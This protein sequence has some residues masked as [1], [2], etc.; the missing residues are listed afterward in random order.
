MLRIFAS[1]WRLHPKATAREF[2]LRE[3]GYVTAGVRELRAAKVGDTLTHAGK[4][5]RAPL[6]ASRRSSPRVFAGLYPVE[7]SE[8]EH[9]AT[10]WRNCT[11]TTHR[12]HYEPE[13]SQA[14]G[15]GFRCGFLVC[16]TW[17]SCRNGSS[18]STA[19]I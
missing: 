4:P 11:S 6:P 1:R 9:C 12:F 16:C 7:A 14:L 2:S 8:Y 10:R 5:A 15:F 18:A 13:T 19:C 3:V 17:T